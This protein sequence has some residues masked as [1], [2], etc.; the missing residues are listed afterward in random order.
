LDFKS[1]YF[2]RFPGKLLCTEDPGFFLNQSIHF[3]PC[4]TI[5]MS[6]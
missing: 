2:K 5:P 4:A 1:E 6:H 3:Y